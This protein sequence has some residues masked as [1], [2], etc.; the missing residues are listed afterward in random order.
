MKKTPTDGDRPKRRL[1]LQERRQ[2]MRMHEAGRSNEYIARYFGIVSRTVASHIKAGH[3]T[4]R[5][6]YTGRG[7]EGH[8][9]R[10]ASLIRDHKAGQ[11]LQSL[12]DKY[13]ITRQRVFSIVRR[14]Y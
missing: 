9:E 6:P 12:A 1:S 2:L 11:T 10:N 7:V 8:P 13:G 14:G 5:E 4:P 3:P